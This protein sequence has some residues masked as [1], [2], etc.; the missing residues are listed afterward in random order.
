[1]SVSDGYIEYVRDLLAPFEPL[2]VKRM[3]GGAGVYSADLF[4]AILVDDTLYLKADGQTRGAF[5]ERG[6][7]PFSYRMKNGRTA[8]MS[9][10][11]LPPEML[12]EPGAL[13]PWVRE[14]LEVARRSARQQTERRGG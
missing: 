12:D 4:F 8:S 5:E 6:L 9:Y 11:P 13:D 10:Y 2:R 14:A 3:F 7:R 1:M